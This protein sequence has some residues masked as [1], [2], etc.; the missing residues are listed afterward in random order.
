MDLDH[1]Y[2]E[3]DHYWLYARL[4]GSQEPASSSTYE[5]ALDAMS[6]DFNDSWQQS[7]VNLDDF[8][9]S[10]DSTSTTDDQEAE[11]DSG[12]SVP[13]AVTSYSETSGWYNSN[14]LATFS[15]LM[16]GSFIWILMALRELQ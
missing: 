13:F 7:K 16:D 4:N 11:Y 12:V 6:L 9:Q 10:S 5:D 2:P 8:T 14:G 3:D 1:N 15:S